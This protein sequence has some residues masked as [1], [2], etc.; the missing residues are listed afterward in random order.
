V[1]EPQNSMLPGHLPLDCGLCTVQRLFTTTQHNTTQPNIS[2]KSKLHILCE[3]FVCLFPLVCTYFY[4]LIHRKNQLAS[5]GFQ[6]QEITA[7]PPRLRHLCQLYR[8]QRRGRSISVLDA[9]ADLSEPC[10]LVIFECHLHSIKKQAIIHLLSRKRTVPLDRRQQ[11]Q[12]ERIMGQRRMP[13]C[14]LR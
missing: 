4:A 3:T 1:P 11:R 12:E 7:T 10:L 8:L 6:L 2:L 5:P 9:V 14:C 13:A